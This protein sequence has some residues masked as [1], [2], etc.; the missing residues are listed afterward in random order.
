MQLV[1]IFDLDKDT[2]DKTDLFKVGANIRGVDAETVAINNFGV[3][4]GDYR[5]QI[6]SSV[7]LD[8][9]DTEHRARFQSSEH[10]I[11]NIDDSE[12]GRRI[13]FCRRIKSS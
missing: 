10:T 5:V 11:V 6:G 9:I 4:V 3:Q 1:T 8:S 12:R 13:L 7:Q 2:G